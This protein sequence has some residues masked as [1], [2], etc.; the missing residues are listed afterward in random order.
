MVPRLILP[1]HLRKKKKSGKKRA[2]TQLICMAYRKQ[3]L[4]PDIGAYFLYNIWFFRSYSLVFMAKSVMHC[5]CSKF[6]Y[7]CLSLKEEAERGLILWADDYELL[8]NKFN[9]AHIYK[10]YA[11]C[12]S[13]SQKW[14]WVSSRFFKLSPK[15]LD[16]LRLL[17]GTSVSKATNLTCLQSFAVSFRWVPSLP[18]PFKVLIIIMLI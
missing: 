16:I 11:G 3:S 15:S 12:L 2:K 10:R 1:Q 17:S 18:F 5:I 6:P 9:Y 13:K 8:V 7:F 14:S 4:K